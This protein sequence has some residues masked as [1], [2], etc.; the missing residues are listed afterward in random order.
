MS[1][2]AKKQNKTRAESSYLNP[3]ESE[4]CPRWQVNEYLVSE[5]KWLKALFCGRQQEGDSSARD[6]EECFWAFD[7]S[8][9]FPLLKSLKSQH[10]HSGRVWFACRLQHEGSW[11]NKI[12]VWEGGAG[13]FGVC[14][15]PLGA[16]VFPYK[17]K[18]LKKTT[19]IWLFHA[20][21]R[22]KSGTSS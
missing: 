2:A 17:D 9:A 14:V 16:R 12:P 11:L 22:W 7:R 10:L 4:I 3:N 15:F 8:N 20:N 13:L 18:N 21:D 5:R 19:H 1:A 6:L